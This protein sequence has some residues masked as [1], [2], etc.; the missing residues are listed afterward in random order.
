LIDVLVEKGI[1]AKS[2]ARTVIDRALARLVILDP[3]DR[4][5]A[6]DFI[7]SLAQQ[8]AARK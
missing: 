1:I 2:D 8:I 4:A 5:D 7:A 6:S 3:K